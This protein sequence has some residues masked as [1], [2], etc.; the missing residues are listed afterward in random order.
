MSELFYN[1]KLKEGLPWLPSGYN[2][3][4]NAEDVGLIL[5]QGN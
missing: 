2:L 5:G 4:C 1:K 3:P